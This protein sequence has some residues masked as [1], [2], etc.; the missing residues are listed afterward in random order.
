MTSYLTVVTYNGLCNR[1]L[2]LISCLRLARKYNKKVNIIWTYTPQRSC[3]TYFGDHCKLLD[4][5]E[6]PDNLVFEK[7]DIEN[8]KTYDFYYWLSLDH[9]IDMSEKGNIYVNYALYPIIG[10]E[11]KSDIFINFKKTL[12]KNQELIFDDVGKE[13]CEEMKKLKPVKDICEQIDLCSKQF[14][15]EMIGI[16]IRKTDGGFVKYDWKS[17][18]KKILNNA[19]KWVNS[20]NDRGIF[21]ATD[22]SDT[23]VEFASSLGSK[24]VFYN[25]SKKLCGITSDNKFN[26]DKFNVICGVVELYLLGK[27]NK[28]IIGTVDSTFSICGMLLADPN[29]KKYLVDNEESVPDFFHS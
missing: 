20:S 6:E 25:P 11:D 10:N 24:L 15:N 1:L 23:Y 12:N 4:L 17:I 21:L 3:L 27:C 29:I 13:L 22:D 5:F 16:H 26:N 19:K 7:T 8:S 18:I 9:V 14:Y 28:M 2:P